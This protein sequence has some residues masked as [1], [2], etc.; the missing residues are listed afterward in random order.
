MDNDKRYVAVP[1]QTM[2][3]IQLGPDGYP[4]VRVSFSAACLASQIVFPVENSEDVIANLTTG[5][6]QAVTKA[7]KK[8]V[9]S[10]MPDFTGIEVSNGH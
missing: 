5:I 6:R 8:Q 10:T 7:T 9:E 1:L 2:V 3:D 4:W